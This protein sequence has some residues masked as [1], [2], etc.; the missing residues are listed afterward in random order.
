MDVDVDLGRI[1]MQVEHRQRKAIRLTQPAICLF[2][3]EGQVAVM[4]A[5][6]INKD[7][8]V[9]PS[10]PMQG[11]W[12][13]QS[14]HGGLLDRQHRRRRLAV[15]DRSEGCPQVTA[16]G[17]LQNPPPVDLQ[18]E[19]NRRIPEGEL[20]DQPVDYRIFGRR[21]LQELES[22][23]SVVE[24]LLDADP[25][26]G[27]TACRLGDEQLRALDANPEP[28]FPTATPADRL[29]FGDG[30]DTGQCFTSKTERSDR[31]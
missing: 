21:L 26:P 27:R 3:R 11:W 14:A 6:P 13:D 16:S 2:Y 9:I 1:D 15:I 7:D 23:R 31:P 19:C 12:A 10:A 22:R 4:D 5:T 17:C 29:D 28:L 30:G 25:R 18:A 24:E 20:A 8:H